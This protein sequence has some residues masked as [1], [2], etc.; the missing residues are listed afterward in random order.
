VVIPCKQALHSGIVAS[1][2]VWDGAIAEVCLAPSVAK[3]SQELPYVF[4]KK[5]VAKPNN[6]CYV[7][8]N[9]RVN[10]I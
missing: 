5:V 4:S 2:A 10:I 7:L 8:L 3:Q 1:E 6:A 9:F